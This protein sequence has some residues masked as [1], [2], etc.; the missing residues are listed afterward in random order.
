MLYVEF[1]TDA[2]EP[3]HI[4]G[5]EPAMITITLMSTL[6]AIVA[7]GANI[8]IFVPKNADGLEFLGDACG[9]RPVTEGF[10]EGAAKH[11]K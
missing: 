1:T 10:F 7:S 3:E 2:C 11:L 4:L 8:A 5:V 6:R 9:G